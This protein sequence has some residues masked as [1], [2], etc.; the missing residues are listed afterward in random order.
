MKK[1]SIIII[2][3]TILINISFSQEE[4]CEDYRYGKFRI[5]LDSDNIETIIVRESNQ[6][7]EY[8]DESKDP[9]ILTVEWIDSCTYLLF[10]SAKEINENEFLNDGDYVKVEIIELKENSY[11]A[12]TT[13]S[14]A[15]FIL[16]SEIEKIDEL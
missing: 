12:K 11:I 2:F 6:Q 3:S 16:I 14:F 13:A 5:L 8:T 10:P 4:T 1:L 7:K 15:D 9:T